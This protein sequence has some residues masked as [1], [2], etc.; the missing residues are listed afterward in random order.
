MTRAGFTLRCRSLAA[1]ACMLVIPLHA[2]ARSQP[3][4]AQGPGCGCDPDYDRDL[5]VDLPDFRILEATFGLALGD[6]GYRSNV[7]S[8]AD[9]VIDARDLAFFVSHWR[10][11]VAPGRNCP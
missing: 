2:L 7:D 11:R 6:P 9:G 4:A 5:V 1:L 3:F 10:H 8:N